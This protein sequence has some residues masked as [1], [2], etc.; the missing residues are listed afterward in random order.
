MRAGQTTGYK[1]GIWFYNGERNYDLVR[2]LHPSGSRIVK[3]FDKMEDAA[4]EALR[5]NDRLRR[6]SLFV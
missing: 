1:V 4:R 5:R 3:T 6:F 2:M